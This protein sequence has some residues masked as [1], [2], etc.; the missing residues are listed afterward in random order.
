MTKQ[1]N[2][3]C[4]EPDLYATHASEFALEEAKVIL[5]G[6]YAEKELDPKLE[7]ILREHLTRCVCCSEFVTQLDEIEEFR[8]GDVSIV[9]VSCPSSLNMDRFLFHPDE[10]PAGEKDRISRHLKDCPLCKEETDWFKN[11]DQPKPI[12]F[13]P[14]RKNWLQY[15]SVAAALFFMTFSVILFWQRASVQKTENRLRALAVIK[16]PDQINYL[17][18][19]N[20][21]VS[22]PD[23]MNVLYDHGVRAIRQRRF[24]EAI[25]NLELVSTAHPNHSASIYLLGYSYYQMNEPEKAFALCDRAEKI[26][27]HSMERCLSLVHIALKTG[28]FG[29]AVQEISGLH[30]EA[31]NHPE[32]QAMYEQITSITRGSTLKL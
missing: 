29:R 4:I 1:E 27:P 8:A 23:K 24:Q 3:G 31:P 17:D 7:S 11:L 13:S 12:P 10:L 21:S 22:L 28:N 26:V 9:H 2:K 16:E 32:V 30:H 18:L 15:V 14:P 5:L 19:K 25:R 6:K 20:S